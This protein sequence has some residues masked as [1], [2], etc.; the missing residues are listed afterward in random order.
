[1]TPAAIRPAAAQDAEAVERLR[2][3]AWKLAYRGLVPGAFLDSMHVDAERRRQGLAEQAG[4]VRQSVASEAGVIVGWVAAGPCRDNDRKEP[5]QGEIYACYVLPGW[6]RNGIGRQLLVHAT[7]ALEVAGRADISLWV[8]EGNDRA[9]RFYES[10]G[11][12]PDGKRQL[13]YLA[14]PVPEVRYHRPSAHRRSLSAARR[15]RGAGD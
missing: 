15:P 10:C 7:H 12:H 13:L 14:G 11:L 3:A 1:M 5:W 2:V 4:E 8:L 6:W 9:R